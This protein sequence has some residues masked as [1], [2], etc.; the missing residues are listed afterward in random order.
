[1]WPER[2]TENFVQ[3]LNESDKL[4]YVHT[5]NKLEEAYNIIKRGV[6]GL[7]TDYLY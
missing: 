5:V 6:Y 4:V 7:Y 2:A 3:R 1:M